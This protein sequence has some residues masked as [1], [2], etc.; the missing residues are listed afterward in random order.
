MSGRVMNVLSSMGFTL[1][2]DQKRQ[3]LLL[4]KEFE[5]CKAQVHT[6]TAERDALRAEVN[7][8]K[9]EVERLKHQVE[10][11]PQAAHARVH[12]PEPMEVEVMKFIGNQRTANSS[13]I[14]KGMNIHSVAC[15]LYLGKLLEAGLI[16]G[17]HV[18]MLGVM[19]SLTHKGNQYLVE[20]KLVPVPGVPQQQPNNPKGHPCDHCGSSRLRRTGAVPDPTFGAVG[21]KA[22]KY[23]C[24]DCGQES[25]FTDDKSTAS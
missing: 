11:K 12:K 18:P 20:N 21:V 10:Q 8:L 3:I 4:D 24:L 25:A 22:F 16:E 13:D 9:K 1:A 6:L 17:G 19:Y 14:Q 7:P 2:Q 15:E 5:T 23:T